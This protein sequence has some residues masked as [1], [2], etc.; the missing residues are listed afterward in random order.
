M[1]NQDYVEKYRKEYTNPTDK[2]IKR[3]D[4]RY[5]VNIKQYP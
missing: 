2:T 4:N 1:A 3:T 5:G